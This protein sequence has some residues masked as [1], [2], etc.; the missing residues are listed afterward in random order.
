MHRPMR[1][2]GVSEPGSVCPS[3]SGAG[4]SVESKLRKEVTTLREQVL[5]CARSAQSCFPARHAIYNS[6]SLHLLLPA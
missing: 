5:L 6:S 3:T 4:S 2:S 1:A